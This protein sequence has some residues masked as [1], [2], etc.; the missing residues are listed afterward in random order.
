MPSASRAAKPTTSRSRNNNLDEVTNDLANLKL[1]PRSTKHAPVNTPSTPSER[2]RN[3]M[4]AVN[5]ASQSISAAVKSGWKLGSAAAAE[6]EWSEAKV[7][8]TMEPVEGALSTLRSIY[9]E[10]GNLAK[11]VDV[12]RAALGVVS[13]L[14]SLQ[15]YKSAL[16]L[17]EGVRP[18]LLSLLGAP[19]M[20]EPRPKSRSAKAAQRPPSRTGTSKAPPH[21]YL[22]LLS[23]P[24]LPESPS[25]TD[26]A[27]IQSL[28]IALAT[29]QAHAI[30]SVLAILDNTQL[31]DL[32]KTLISPDFLLTRAPPRSTTLP[33]DQLSALF[34]GAFQSIAGS[35]ALS[36]RPPEPATS[37]TVRKTSSGAPSVTRAHTRTAS[38][39]GTTKVSSASSTKPA[40]KPTAAAS[41]NSDELALLCRKEALLILA[42]SP[43]VEKDMNLFWDQATKWG[44]VYVKSVSALSSP[45]TEEQIAQTLSTFFSDLIATI[46]SERQCG[47]RFETLCEWW[48]RFAKK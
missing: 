12:E 8:K 46:S 34:V 41:P 15:M 47:A 28:S 3:A 26:T 18:S 22:P 24:Q 20:K 42:R 25:F 29:Y 19:E 4:L 7:N 1:Q 31:H 6:P 21:P 38:A 40:T 33:A 13:K 5:E 32:Y 9:Q 44:A 17:L 14:N 43:S 10:Q 35:P 39:S 11:I 16:G 23:L 48:T 2:L 36:P 45:P 27:S 37:S 30:K